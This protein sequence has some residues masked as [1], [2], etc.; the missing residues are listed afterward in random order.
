MAIL[1]GVVLIV[2]FFAIRLL[3][4]PTEKDFSK[5][6]FEITVPRGASLDVM[7]KMF[8]DS[9]M[10]G[11]EWQFVWAARLTGLD[12]KLRAGKYTFF[13]RNISPV[14]L[15]K[16]LTVGGSFDVPVTFPEGLTVYEVARIASDSLKIPFKEFLKICF[17]RK[18]LDSLGI[19]APSCEGYLFPETYSLP[20]SL[21]AE[22]LILRMYS[23]FNSVW[24][25]NFDRRAHE[26]GM[27]RNSAITLASIIEGE[28]RVARERTIVSSVYNNRLRKKMLLQADPTVIYGL[29]CFERALTKADLDTSSS[30]YNTYR[31]PGLPPGPINSPG[32]GAI[33]AAL[34]PDS[35]DYIYFVSNEDGTHWFTRTLD[36][37]YNA[38]HAIRY[39]GERGPDPEI[40]TSNRLNNN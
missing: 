4:V 13:A 17:D 9:G 22:E 12:R 3:A 14:D 32:K 27:D 31:F 30:K 5:K 20:E 34:W 33:R 29:Q 2:S 6:P 40:I 1:I 15:V 8:A 18:F 25:D 39:R 36:E 37:H 26:L 11:S 35:T 21:S 19:D 10:V 28:A 16:A 23:H 38:I 7:A 24:N